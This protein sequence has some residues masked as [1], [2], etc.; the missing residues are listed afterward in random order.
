MVRFRK[1]H[2]EKVSQY[3]K[4]WYLKNRDKVLQRVAKWRK[5][6]PEKDKLKNE[7]CGIK[8]RAKNREKI[9]LYSRRYVKIR[10]KDEK[11]KLRRNLGNRISAAIRGRRML[12]NTSLIGCSIEKLKDHLESKFKPGMTWCNYGIKGWHIDHIKPCASFDLHDPLQ[13]AACFHWS[14]LQPLWAKENLRKSK[15]IQ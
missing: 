7:K 6:N 5:E 8:Y 14:N 13:Q 11:F 4:Q 9:R 3:A 10:L 12:D 15:K 2:K 1:N